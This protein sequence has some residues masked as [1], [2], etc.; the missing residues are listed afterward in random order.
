MLDSV[1]LV[2]SAEKSKKERKEYRSKDNQSEQ[3][4][5]TKHEERHA[6]CNT[7]IQ[8][9]RTNDLTKNRDNEVT[10]RRVQGITI[11]GK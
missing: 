3:T 6:D 8:N 1:D 2:V 5:E 10:K 4:T 11:E 9:A 7:Q